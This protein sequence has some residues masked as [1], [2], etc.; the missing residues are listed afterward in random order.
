M[1]G[2]FRAF[3]R[4]A[5]LL[6]LGAG[7]AM[8]AAARTAPQTMLPDGGHVRY[9]ETTGNY[10]ISDAVTGSR[11][12]HVLCQSQSGWKSAGLTITRR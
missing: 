7:A 10:C 3:A 8:P 1:I 12:P 2:Q 9:D 11:I 6:A 4:P 5:L